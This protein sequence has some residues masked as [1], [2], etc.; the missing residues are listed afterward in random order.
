[1]QTNSYTSSSKKS[2]FTWA[3]LIVFIIILT[4]IL[5]NVG[6]H[7]EDIS[8]QNQ[9]T[10]YYKLAWSSFYKFKPHVMDVL[11]LGSSHAYCSFDPEIMD[12]ALG[13]QSFNLGSPLQHG[14]SSYFVFKEAI[15]HQKPDVLVFE[16][17]WDMLDTEFEL[18]QADTVIQAIDNEDFE[19]EFV[20][21]AFP[22]NELVKYNFKPVRYQQD[23]YNYWNHELT[24]KA[25]EKLSLLTEDQNDSNGESYYK[26]RGFIYS[27]IVIPESE[28][29]ET[30]QFVGFDGAKWEF[31]DTQ[32][33]YIKRLVDLA[34]KEG[35]KTIFVTAPVANISMEHIENYEDVHNKI[36]AFADE[37][38]VPYRDYNI[39]NMEENLF[40]NENFRDDA[41]FNYS[42]VEIFM[43]DFIEWY[44]EV[45]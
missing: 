1:M 19:R 45:R 22:L 26:Y 33:S 38:G 20:E 42:G 4:I 5:Y 14:D 25:E 30:N 17:Y 27:D 2:R 35:I 44:K 18:K 32:K 37:L 13:I 11:F 43:E 23:V 12:D 21:E 36:A 10:T 41:H 16:I 7:F 9:S 28:F 6:N 15:K 24:E 40:E 3:K 39:V 31:D 29:Y 34:N 8:E